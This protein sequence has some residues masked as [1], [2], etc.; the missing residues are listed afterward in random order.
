[1][2]TVTSPSTSV[3]VT[4]LDN[5]DSP[6]NIT[7]KKLDTD[8][9]I[10]EQS[11]SDNEPEGDDEPLIPVPENTGDGNEHEGDDEPLIPVPEHTNDDNEPEGDDEPLI[12]VPE[13]TNDD[14][15]HEGDDEPLFLFQNKLKMTQFM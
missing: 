14:N 4:L 10:P 5:N 3:T 9:F 11:D 7:G 12:P 1:M 13:N 6:P 2:G 8:S 15:E